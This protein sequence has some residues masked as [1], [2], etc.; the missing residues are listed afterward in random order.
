MNT[1][2]LIIIQDKKNLMCFKIGLLSGN[3]T[4]LPAIQAHM[5]IPTLYALNQ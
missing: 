3:Y 4:M 2:V 1:D 5:S